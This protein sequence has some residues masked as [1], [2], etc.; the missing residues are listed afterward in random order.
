MAFRVVYSPEA[1]KDLFEIYDYLVVSVTVHSINPHLS[2]HTILMAPEKLAC[3]EFCP[4]IS[5]R[6]QYHVGLRLG[7]TE[8]VQQ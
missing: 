1:R 6:R 3:L 5:D 8:I 4:M 2:A 7:V